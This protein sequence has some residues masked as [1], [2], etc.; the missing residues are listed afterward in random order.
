MKRFKKLNPAKDAIIKR[1]RV[2]RFTKHLLKHPNDKQVK[3]IKL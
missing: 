2:K 3:Y 1:N